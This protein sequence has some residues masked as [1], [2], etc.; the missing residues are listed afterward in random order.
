[1]Y[2]HVT[3]I[4]S[5]H[6]S[7]IYYKSIPTNKSINKANNFQKGLIIFTIGNLLLWYVQICY[8][9]YRNSQAKKE[10]Q[11]QVRTISC[12]SQEQVRTISC[13]S[14][15]QVRTISCQSLVVLY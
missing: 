2:L 8:G 12:Q 13:Q 10:N 7:T 5:L 6:V 1:M 11:E 4:Y 3:A 15:E 9:L 14:Q